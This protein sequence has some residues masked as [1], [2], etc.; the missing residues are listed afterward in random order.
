MRA[1]CIDVLRRGIEWRSTERRLSLH[2]CRACAGLL[3]V[4]QDIWVGMGQARQSKTQ[5]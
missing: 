2:L 1:C 3:K 5:S 4:F